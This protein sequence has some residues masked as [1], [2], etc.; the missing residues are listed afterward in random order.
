M[1]I[2]KEEMLRINAGFGGGLISDSNLDYAIDIQK[3]EKLGEYKKIAYLWRAI[4]VDRPFTDGN[5]RTAMYLALKFAEESKKQVDRELL[6]HHI[7]SIAKNN[8]TDIRNI[9]RRI[10]NAVR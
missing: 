8:E 5:K 10:Q 1:N 6:L 4:L 7:V 2:S 3:N 9:E